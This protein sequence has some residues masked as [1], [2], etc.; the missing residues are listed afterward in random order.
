MEPEAKNED[1]ACHSCLLLLIVV[2]IGMIITA[3]GGLP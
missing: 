3:L 2:L 1:N